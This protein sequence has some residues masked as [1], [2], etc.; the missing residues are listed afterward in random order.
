MIH[1]FDDVVSY[2]NAPWNLP[3]QLEL[4]IS[5]VRRKIISIEA[6]CQVETVS[7]RD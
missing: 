7:Y 6:V 1:R 4:I 2:C 3:F 5:L